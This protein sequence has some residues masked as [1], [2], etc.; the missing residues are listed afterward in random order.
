MNKFLDN[1]DAYVCRLPFIGWLVKR[2]LV[3][4]K[5]HIVFTDFIHIFLGFGLALLFFN[6]ELLTWG[7]ALL[8]I[9]ILGHIYAFIKVK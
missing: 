3:Y 6:K 8:G 4:F 2:L 7:V 1:L 9:A 5:N